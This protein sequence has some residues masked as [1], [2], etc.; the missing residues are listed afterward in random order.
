MDD[1]ARTDAKAR[2]RAI[3]GQPF[4]AP[5]SFTLTVM[6]HRLD[7]DTVAEWRDVLGI[8]VVR[9]RRA[10]RRNCGPS[11]T[12]SATFGPADPTMPSRPEKGSERCRDH[13]PSSPVP[14]L[15]EAGAGTVRP[16]AGHRRVG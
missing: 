4:D 5:R 2:L 16:S 3:D 10:K 1:S 15:A 11:R 12:W 13:P 8:L 6:Q 9:S 14:V 7:A